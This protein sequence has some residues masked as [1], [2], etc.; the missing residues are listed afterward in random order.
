MQKALERG[1]LQPSTA[2]I[3][4]MSETSGVMRPRLS[5]RWRLDLFQLPTSSALPFGP[6]EAELA[7]KLYKDLPRARGRE[8]HLALAAHAILQDAILWTLNPRETSR[9]S[10]VWVCGELVVKFR[11]PRSCRTAPSRKG[12]TVCLMRLD[13]TYQRNGGV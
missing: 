3:S 9:T 5:S 8:I 2:P 11:L 4:S 12:S 1:L 13:R 6:A 10:L 7:S